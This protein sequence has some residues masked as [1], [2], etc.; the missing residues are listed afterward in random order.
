MRPT[1]P[2]GQIG[3][4]RAFPA[5]IKPSTHQVFRVEPG[6][7]FAH[8]QAIFTDE[9][10]I[11]IDFAAAVFGTLNRDEVP[12]N[13]ASVAV[14]GFLVG[15]AGRKMK[16]SGDLLVKKNVPHRLQNEWVKPVLEITDAVN[17]I[18]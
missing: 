10:I 15:L 5:A 2:I 4:M 17:S 7:L 13:L 11:K 9:L 16:G 1:G 3:P 18:F 12:V 6:Q 8:E 14:V